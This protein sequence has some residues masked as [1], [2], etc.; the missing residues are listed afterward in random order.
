MNKS[1]HQKFRSNIIMLS[2]II[3]FIF[4]VINISL[5]IINDSYLVK[6]IKEENS[7]FLLLSTHIINDNEIPVALEYIKHYTHIYEVEVEVLDAEKNMLFSS[8]V[9]HKY[10][11][12]FLIETEKGEFT[13]FID[14]TNST[15]VN[16]IEKNTIYVNASLLAI[17]ILSLIVL[18]KNNRMTGNQIDHDMKNL[19]N[20]INYEKASDNKFNLVEFQNINQVITSYLE[21]I[22]LLTEQKEMNMKGLAHD[23]KTPLTV[24]YSYFERVLRNDILNEKDAKIAF[25][26]A[27]RVDGLI[28]DIIEDNK[29]HVYKTID[30][31]KI[32][33]EKI[34][35]Y[36]P[37]FDN[38]DIVVKVKNSQNVKFKWC[39]IDFL[40][41]IDNIISNA[42]YYSKEN[43]IFEIIVKQDERIVIEFISIP[44]DIDDIDV[45][46][47]FL[48]G[49]RGNLSSEKNTYG[50]GYGLYLCKLL[51]TNVDG[52][53]TVNKTN[54]NV[55]FT[56][57][58]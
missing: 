8:A 40:R 52:E 36:K 55:K 16:S 14:N 9:A 30:L 45:K 25:D 37:I 46:E 27:K 57:T 20:L 29:R 34:E 7:A 21:S 47:I 28:N 12:Q 13:I 10:S 51:L 23:I 50:K 41:V 54:K 53:I 42:Y 2:I 35:E 11:N 43:S 31:S 19:L 26:S 24:I 17:Y 44:I 33:A 56:I 39:E 15:T 49:F 6:K 22:D 38:K 18:I 32:I 4:L 58:L 48:K 1:I 5:Y 3:T